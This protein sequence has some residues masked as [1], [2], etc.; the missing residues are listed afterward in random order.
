MSDGNGSHP[1][2]SMSDDDEVLATTGRA[3]RRGSFGPGGGAGI[4]TE[5]SKDFGV[6]VRRLG[7]I[8]GTETPRLVG[9]AA[10]PSRVLRSSSW[11]RVCSARPPTS[12]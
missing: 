1:P 6:T 7:T 8:L 9:V 4:P 10:S 3:A 5:R 2:G 12:S 11:G